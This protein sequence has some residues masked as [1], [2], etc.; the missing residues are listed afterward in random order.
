MLE[1]WSDDFVWP[2]YDGKTIANIPSTVAALLDVPFNGLPPLEGDLWHSVGGDVKRVV[3]ILMD[4]LGWNIVSKQTAPWRNWVDSADIKGQLTSVFPSTT[5]NALST[6]WTGSAAG[7]HG[8]VGLRIFFPEYGVIGQMLSLSPEFHSAPDLLVNAG[9][10]AVNFLATESVGTQFGRHGVQTF[11]I[12]GANIVDSALS[13]MHDRDITGECGYFTSADM[14]V[15]LRDIL[16]S[17]GDQKLYAN[18]Y[19]PFVDTLSHAHGPHSAHVAAETQTIFHQIQTILF[20]QLSAEAREGTVVFI[21]GRPR[22][23]R[24]TNRPARLHFRSSKA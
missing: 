9:L 21:T 20:D 19:W 12:K 8:L 17:S 3:V 1:S 7:Q 18:V 15:Q 5:V 24:N 10:D 22:S 14:L 11:A 2:N 4:A 13:K 6:V 16:E 23:G